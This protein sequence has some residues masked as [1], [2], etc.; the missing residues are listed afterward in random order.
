M[1]RET[2]HTQMRRP[3]EER[4]EDAGLDSSEEGTIQEMPTVTRSWKRQRSNSPLK[5]SKRAWYC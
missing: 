3:C 4:S 5:P 1:Q 2:G